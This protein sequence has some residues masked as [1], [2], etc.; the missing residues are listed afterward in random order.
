MVKARL[1]VDHIDEHSRQEIKLWAEE[2][3]NK[4]VEH[5]RKTEF[6]ARQLWQEEA[7][8]EVESLHCRLRN[9]GE[10]WFELMDSRSDFN[11]TRRCHLLIQP[12]YSNILASDLTVPHSM[13]ELKGELFEPLLIYM[14]PPW[15]IASSSPYRGLSLQYETL[16]AAE[17]LKI[18]FGDLC[19]DGICVMWCT[20][21]TRTLSEK[22][23]T[24]QRFRIVDQL[25]WVKR[26]K[27]EGLHKGLGYYTQHACEHA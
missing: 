10:N 25:T 11:R 26:T 13:V 21:A 12:P 22:I 18:Q 17:L 19:K 20:H 1:V 2:V 7:L 6:D 3:L 24:N 4:L 23:L 27:K 8:I 5:F 9:L 16:S 15:R 14:D